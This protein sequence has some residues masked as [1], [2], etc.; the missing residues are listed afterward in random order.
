MVKF[1]HPNHADRD[2]PFRIFQHY[3]YRLAQAF[4]T[5]ADELSTQLMGAGLISREKWAEV[6]LPQQTSIQK[7]NFLLAAIAPRFEID[8]GDKT[9]RQLCKLMSKHKHLK[10]LSRRIMNKYGRS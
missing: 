1:L 5:S 9:L 6:Q 2:L 8:G 4:G 3:S 7:G 10:K